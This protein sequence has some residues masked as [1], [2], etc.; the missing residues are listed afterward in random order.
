MWSLSF[1]PCVLMFRVVSVNKRFYVLERP[2]SI[3]KIQNLP[4]SKH[5]PENLLFHTHEKYYK[6]VKV[7]LQTGPEHYHPASS[8]V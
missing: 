1:C 8:L 6:N 3:P 7:L 2:A 5:P 4:V